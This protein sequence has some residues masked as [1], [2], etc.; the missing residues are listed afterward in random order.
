MNRGSSLVEVLVALT[1]A[2]VVFVAATKLAV[3]SVRSNAY[4]E[5]LTYASVLGHTKLTSLEHLPLDSPDLEDQWHQ[6]SANPFVWGGRQFY[7]FWQV[8]AALVGKQVVVHVAWNDSDRPGAGGIG[9]LESL[10]QSRCPS[11]A[12]S[13]MVPD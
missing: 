13:A 7:R 11:V 4:A 6:D 1:V 2:M 12:F 9:S 10:M 3:L 8:D 5:S